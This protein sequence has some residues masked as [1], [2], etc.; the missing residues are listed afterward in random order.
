VERKPR[1]TL[2]KDE[3]LKARKSIEDIFNSGESFSLY[4]LR[5]FFI[6]EKQTNNKNA[7]SN[8]KNSSLQFGVGVSKK[9]FK[10]AVDRNRI[11]R[12]IREAYRLQKKV[13]AMDLDAKKDRSLKLFIL[14]TG[15]ELP[16]HTLI[17]QKVGETL[18][19]L[20]RKLEL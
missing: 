1:Y 2:G 4:P 12:L 10:K 3:R 20:K 17:N 19:R 11:K 6:L 14:Y 9:N 8:R 16:E 5:V 15:S 18:D 13:I 7:A